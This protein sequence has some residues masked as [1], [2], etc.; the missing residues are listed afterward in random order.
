MTNKKKKELKAQKLEELNKIFENVKE[1]NKVLMN[2]LIEQACFMYVQLVDLNEKI[3]KNGVVENFKQ[4]KQEFQRESPASKT[5][6]AM[7][8]NYNATIKQLSEFIPP[9]QTPKFDDEFEE[10]KKRRSR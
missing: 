8:K 5:Y 6:N 7:V 4:G 1:N 2:G 9:G 3:E 10:F